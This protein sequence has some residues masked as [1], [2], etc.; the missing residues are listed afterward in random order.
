MTGWQSVPVAA[1]LPT[2]PNYLVGTG[3]VGRTLTAAQSASLGGA[4]ARYESDFAQW[5]DYHWAN[6]GSAW[7]ENYYD[8]AMIYY[9]MW[10]RTGKPVYF[11]RA[12]VHAF[13]YRKG[14]L[15]ASNYG[16]APHWALME[17]LQ[18]HYL[19]TGDESSRYA[20]ANIAENLWGGYMPSYK[21]GAA[22]WDLRIVAR[23]MT[24]QVY[25]QEIDGRAVIGAWSQ[26]ATY[27]ER[28]TD[29]VGQL[30]GWQT[31]EG[32][33]PQ[34][35]YCRGQSN[36][37]AGLLN[38]ALVQVYER[39]APDPRILTLVRR[40]ADHLWNTQWVPA[41]QGFQYLNVNCTQEVGSTGA[42]PDLT[43]MMVS[44]YSWLGQR[45]GDSRYRT[46]G[47]QVFAAG[48]ANTY[49]IGSKQ[50]NEAYTNSWSYTAWR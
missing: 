48:I 3:I 39:S 19:L 9:V 1:A 24:L 8:R 18:K 10:A 25:A 15:E 37:M 5:A 20:V 36:F 31:A 29:G 44:A 16:P 45:T 32:S 41:A 7:T 13:N 42:A 26:P 35:V 23:A 11:H 30:V 2:D 40:S 28:I 47:D 4:F 6:N 21:G 12:A 33:Y 50:F 14:Y 46:I 17:G 49:L 27:G 43:Q 34:D 22:S 38:D